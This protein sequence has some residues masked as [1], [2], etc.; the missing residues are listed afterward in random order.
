[1]KAGD[2]YET[3][4]LIHKTILCHIPEEHSVLKG[5]LSMLDYEGNKMF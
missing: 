1:M 4:V 5:L 3:L 2:L